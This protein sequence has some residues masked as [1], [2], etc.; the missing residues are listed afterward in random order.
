MKTKMILLTAAF[1]LTSALALGQTTIFEENFGTF[2]NGTSLSTSNTD[3]TYVRVGT[4]G[5]SIEAF[6][7]SSFGSG[8]SALITG[9]TGGSLNGLGVDNSLD[10]QGL[11]EISF[12]LDFRISDSSGQIV[13]GLG[14]GNSFTSNLAFNTSQGL[15]WFQANGLDFQRRTSSSW[16]S[17]TTLSLDTNYSLLIEANTTTNLMS[18]SLNG[19]SIASD[20]AVTT[21]GIDPTGFRVYSVNGSNV[22]LDNISI[23]AIPEPGTL[24]LVALTGVAAIVTLRRKRA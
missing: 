20:V 21:S 6:N 10:F 24:A 11:D 23:T 12:A 16:E 8:A 19:S 14:D 9:P 17:M 13:F 3:L 7:P 15:F 22:E 5:G 18:I 2:A 1:G 4:Q